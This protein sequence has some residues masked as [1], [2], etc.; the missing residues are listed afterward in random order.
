MARSY[1]GHSATR[2][3]SWCVDRPQR[4]GVG[5]CLFVGQSRLVA[6]SGDDGTVRI[7]NADTKKQFSSSLSVGMEGLRT[8]AVRPGDPSVA[9]AGGNSTVT[10]WEPWNLR[11]ACRLSRPY[12]SLSVSAPY[13]KQQRVASVC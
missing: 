1:V 13:L 7:W 12:V 11:E 5:G 8:V 4:P 3:T 2:P 9:A 10:F 6:S